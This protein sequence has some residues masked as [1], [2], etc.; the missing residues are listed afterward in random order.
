LAP[1]NGTLVLFDLQLS[2][3]NHIHRNLQPPIRPHTR[4][5]HEERE[6]SHG[7][8][9]DFSD[10]ESSDEGNRQFAGKSSGSH[11][12]KPY[13]NVSD[14]EGEEE[15]ARRHITEEEDPFADPF[16]D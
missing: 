16:G 12:R 5:S 7:S 14:D 1:N 15:D 11:V 4:S 10:Y 6:W 8:L 2:A 13:V 3:L 9:S